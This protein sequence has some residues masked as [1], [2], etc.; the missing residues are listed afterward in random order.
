MEH[1]EQFDGKTTNKVVLDKVE[2]FYGFI[3]FNTASSLIFWVFV[4]F[5]F[6]MKPFATTPSTE[7]VTKDEVVKIAQQ[8]SQEGIYLEARE[9]NERES[10]KGLERGFKNELVYP[11]KSEIDK[12]VLLGKRCSEVLYPDEKYPLDK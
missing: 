10:C 11:N 3:Y 4:F 2:K 6:I 7:T 8:I 9:R 5:I 1:K 12:R